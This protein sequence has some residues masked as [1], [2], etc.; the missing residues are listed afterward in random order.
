MFCTFTP[1]QERQTAIKNALKAD[2]GFTRYVGKGKRDASEKDRFMSVVQKRAVSN[3]ALTPIA[4][5]L[6]RD[7]IG[8]YIHIPIIDRTCFGVMTSEFSKN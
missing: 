3:V 4:S 2:C 6:F 1:A 7:I 5:T 8:E